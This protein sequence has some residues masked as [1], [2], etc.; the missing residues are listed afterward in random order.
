VTATRDPASGVSARGVSPRALDQ[1]RRASGGP[2]PAGL[3][4]RPAVRRRVLVTAIW[5]GLLVLIW[6]WWHQTPGSAALGTPALL[7]AGGRLAGLTGGYLLLIQILLMSRVPLIDRAVSGHRGS[8][9]HR[10]LGGYV[11]GVIALHIVLVTLGYAATAKVGVWHEAW[12]LL[13]TYQDMISALVAFLLMALLGLVAVRAVRRRLPYGLWHTIH[14]GTYLILLCVYGHQFADGQ[15]F[16]LS[17][18]A[19]AYWTTL[20]LLVV[21]ALLYGR[22]LAPLVLHL[23]YRLHVIAVVPEAPGVSSV[24]LGGRRL[25]RFPAVAGQYVRWRFLT[26]DGWWRSHP[27]S[28][29]AAPHRGWLRLTVK[30]AGDHSERMHALVPGTRVVTE[31]PA[32]EFT[33]DHRT[34]EGA[35]LIGAGSGIAPVRALLETLPGDVVA[36]LRARTDEDLLFTAE[37]ERMPAG[38]RAVVHRITGSRDDPGPAALATP[39]GLRELYVCGPPGFTDVI[40]YAL[41]TAQVPPRCVHVDAFEL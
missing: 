26:R 30:T 3:P 4:G 19:R 38:R 10:D 15:Q 5:A 8:T 28:L 11:I 17:G 21:A 24:Y 34:R 25:D 39:E 37:I 41:L 20:Y 27:F 6:F 33:A 23:R 36:I 32:G 31:A 14:A 16:V 12:T 18:A 22:V 7:T 35:L 1:A 40:V 2:R 9:W 29:S 13:T